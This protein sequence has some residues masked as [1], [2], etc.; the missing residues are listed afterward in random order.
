MLDLRR[1]KRVLSSSLKLCDAAEGSGHCG[2]LNRLSEQT[3][4]RKAKQGSRL[5]LHHSSRCRLSTWPKGFY[6][7]VCCDGLSLRRIRLNRGEH[8]A[9]TLPP[10]QRKGYVGQDGDA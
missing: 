9:Y 4:S 3:K 6:P 2:V 5:T 7:V 1:V 10:V 8:H